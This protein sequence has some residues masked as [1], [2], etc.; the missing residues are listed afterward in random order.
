MGPSVAL[1]GSEL[2]LGAPER[3]KS[4][5]LTH[6]PPSERAKEPNWTLP[7]SPGALDLEAEQLGGRGGPE[8]GPEAP[9]E[10]R[11]RRQPCLGPEWWCPRGAPGW[12]PAAPHRA[13]PSTPALSL[14]WANAGRSWLAGVP[15]PG[16]RGSCHAGAGHHPHRRRSTAGRG[17]GHC[18]PRHG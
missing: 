17:E 8:P 16:V 13:L 12:G 4:W 10:K 14:A 9:P 5:L 11:W 1:Q 18:W 15:G 3:G 2:L 6:Q 7:A